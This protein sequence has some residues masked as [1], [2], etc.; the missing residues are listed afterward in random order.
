MRR[1]NSGRSVWLCG[2]AAIALVL[3]ALGACGDEASPP[4]EGASP[5]GGA[6]GGSG[7]S[8]AAGGSG[9]QGGSAGSVAG[10]SGG[11]GGGAGSMSADPGRPI[12]TGACR[13]EGP[14]PDRLGSARS[15]LYSGPRPLDVLAE[16]RGQLFVL[17]T[18]DG[19]FR[20]SEG[21]TELERVVAVPTAEFLVADLNLYWPRDKGLWRASITATD[22]T[23]A[24]IATQLAHE[25]ALL[26]YDGTHLYFADPAAGG[27]YRVAIMG[28]ALQT[29]AASTIKVRDQAVQ[30]GFVFLADSASK[31]VQRL[32][33]TGGEAVAASPVALSELTALA[34]DGDTVYWADDFELVASTKADPAA[35]SSLAIAGPRAS[36]R[37][38]RVVWLELAGERLFFRD[39][40]GNV[41]WSALDG[42]S[43]ALVVAGASGLA[44][45]DV[46]ADGKVAYLSVAM[47]A[48]HE[49]WRVDLP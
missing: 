5:D 20:L 49:L 10:G 6:Q 26:R 16:R 1:V 44:G 41:G 47:G 7:G 34:T 45:A 24:P 29:I 2:S 31:R 42:K 43:C 25:I 37:P 33:L 14:T 35:R 11:S 12:P 22:A 17:D 18:M 4:N 48:L 38:A 27:A 15:V 23:P 13:P 3:A 9:G 39:D 8:V 46:D 19:I 32:P 21:E 36:G 40:G 28:G 30:S